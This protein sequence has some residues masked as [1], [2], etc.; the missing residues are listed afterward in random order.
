M[1][2][3]LLDTVEERRHRLVSFR[4]VVC[5]F[6]IFPFF[7]LNCSVVFSYLNSLRPEPTDTG[8]RERAINFVACCPTP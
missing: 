3:R 7:R 5:Y 4:F 1:A 6:H 8:R 2:L